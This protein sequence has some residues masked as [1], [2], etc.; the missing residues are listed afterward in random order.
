MLRGSERGGRTVGERGR[1]QWGVVVVGTSSRQVVFVQ[2]RRIIM[3]RVGWHRWGRSYKTRTTHTRFCVTERTHSTKL[4]RGR[5][6]SSKILGVRQQ[7]QTTIPVVVLLGQPT[8][9]HCWQKLRGMHTHTVTRHQ[10][11]Q[12]TSCAEVCLGSCVDC[13]CACAHVCIHTYQQSV[14]TY[15][16]GQYCV[17]MTGAAVRIPCR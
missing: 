15:T 10:E 13:M 9:T 12:D 8:H 1:G 16:E 11:A 2:H 3:C 14:T 5:S 4:Q 7:E 6:C 17:I